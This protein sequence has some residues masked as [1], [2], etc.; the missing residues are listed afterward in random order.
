MHLDLEATGTII[1][2]YV[3]Y[4]LSNCPGAVKQY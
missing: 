3:V 1:C 4:M 2:T